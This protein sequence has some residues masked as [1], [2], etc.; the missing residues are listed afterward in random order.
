ME[1][2]LWLKDQC[3]LIDHIVLI[4]HWLL[5]FQELMKM[6]RVKIGT[7]IVQ[8]GQKMGSAEQIQITCSATAEKLVISADFTM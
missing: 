4:L 3:I 2:M 7:A 6:Q 1:T 8:L 5:L